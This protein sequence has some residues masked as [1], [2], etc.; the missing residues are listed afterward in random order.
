MENNDLPIHSLFFSISGSTYHHRQM[1]INSNR[2]CICIT[3]SVL[4]HLHEVNW[5]FSFE[6]KEK[7][8]KI[9]DI[10]IN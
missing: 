10:K 9:L 4:E 3:A 5:F 2:F 8:N 7:L 6:K 1:N